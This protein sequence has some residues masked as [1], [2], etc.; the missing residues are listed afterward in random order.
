MEPLDVACMKVGR[1]IALE[2]TLFTLEKGSL[3]YKKVASVVEGIK[4]G[5]CG[6]IGATC[7]EDGAVDRN[8]CGVCRKEYR[9]LRNDLSSFL[10]ALVD[11]QRVGH[12]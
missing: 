4:R 2:D 3:V 9:A 11:G 5:G 1:L 12:D 6:G 10:A 8:K 7:A